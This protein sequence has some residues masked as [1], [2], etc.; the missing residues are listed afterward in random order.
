VVLQKFG[1]AGA[2]PHWDGG[3]ADPTDTRSYPTYVTLSN[4]IGVGQT[5]WVQVG[6][7]K[8]LRT[9]GLRPLRMGAW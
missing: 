3:V 1:D 2:P 9:L 7:P 5:V 8:I 4:L 6:V